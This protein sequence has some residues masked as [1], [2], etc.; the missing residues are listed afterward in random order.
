MLIMTTLQSWQ[1]II[2]CV[3]IVA[4]LIWVVIEAD[5]KMAERAAERA[6]ASAEP[7]SPRHLTLVSALPEPTPQPLYD[8][9]KQGI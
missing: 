1:T 7:D 4:L 3:V 5:K 2:V 8:W 6:A 9:E